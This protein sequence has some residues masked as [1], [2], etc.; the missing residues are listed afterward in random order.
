MVE[1]LATADRGV[2]VE[3]VSSE[4]EAETEVGVGNSGVN[5][6]PGVSPTS[7]SGESI[8]SDGENVLLR[9]FGFED[10]FVGSGKDSGRK[11]TRHKYARAKRERD[12]GLN[13]NLA[14]EELKKL[15]EKDPLIQDYRKSRPDQMVEQDGLRYNLWVRK[16]QPGYTVEQLLLPKQYHQI[17]CKLA[18]SIP[19]AGHLGWDKTLSRVTRWFY[20]PTVYRDVAEY[21]RGIQSARKLLKGV[22]LGYH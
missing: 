15:Q 3:P 17:M 19:I 21:C 11:K 4:S 12:N 22:I 5:G 8:P 7:L 6:I 2:T 13:L 9:E 18:H 16:Q 1:R 14:K 20:W 10:V